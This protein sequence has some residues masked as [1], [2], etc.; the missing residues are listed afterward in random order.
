MHLAAFIV[1][2]FRKAVNVVV[3]GYPALFNA[4][5][6]R[7]HYFPDY[8]FADANGPDLIGFNQGIN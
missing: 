3:H 6:V 2:I 8:G 1:A 7:P 4:R 5:L